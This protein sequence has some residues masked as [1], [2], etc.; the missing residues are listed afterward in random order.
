MKLLKRY[1]D[2]EAWIETTWESEEKFLSDFYQDVS[3]LKLVGLI[4]R[5]NAAVYKVVA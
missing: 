1:L 3:L 5:T 4:F 2:E